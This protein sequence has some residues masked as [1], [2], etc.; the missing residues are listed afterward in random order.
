M[1]VN[2]DQLPPKTQRSSVN[3]IKKL[4]L[5]LLMG[6]I[7]VFI[8]ALLILNFW[9]APR[10]NQYRP[11]LE[12]LF[13]ERMGTSLQIGRLQARHH[14]LFP[15]FY[16]YDATLRDEHGQIALTVGQVE[17]HLSLWA[18]F[19]FDVQF[20]KLILEEPTLSIKRRED[21]HILI[22][23]IDITDIMQNQRKTE[24][25]QGLPDSLLWLL[26]QHQ[27]QIHNGKLS[28]S[29]NTNNAPDILVSELNLDIRKQQRKHFLQ[30]KATPPHA[31]GLPF[32]IEARFTEPT[33]SD[34]S[35]YLDWSGQIQASF[36]QANIE[37]LRHYVLL[38]FEIEKGKGSV[39]IRM[40][41]EHGEITQ[42][43]A[44]LQLAEVELQTARADQ[45]IRLLNLKG[46]F[47]G[48]WIQQVYRIHT[49]DL[50]FHLPEQTL[51]PDITLKEQDWQTGL[52]DISWAFD[53]QFRLNGG[54][55]QTGEIDL[56]LLANLA[57]RL[58]LPE[59]IQN[60]LV[61]SR[62]SGKI[63][64]IDLQW[65]GNF[66]QINT[67]SIKG[68]ISNLTLQAAPVA[69]P[70][71]GQKM[72]ITRPGLEKLNLSF[73]VTEQQGTIKLQMDEGEVTI[74]GLFSIPTLPISHLSAQGQW[75]WN[76]QGQVEFKIPSL[77][78]RNNSALINAQ[79][80]WL[81]PNP[82]QPED[83][84]GYLEL[85]GTLQKVQLNDIAR[86]L[87]NSIMP[88][89]RNYL[90]G[91]IITGI[92][93]QAQVT[94]KG[95]LADF[96]YHKKNTGF[97]LIEGKGRNV[98]FNYVPDAVRPPQQRAWPAFEQ[99]SADI[100]VTG[101]GLRA[102]HINGQ[103]QGI[104]DIRFYAPVLYID[105]W[106][107]HDTHVIANAEL[108]GPL[109][110]YLQ[111]IN[112]S[113]LGN[114]MH[115]TLSQASGTGSIKADLQLD[116]H[117]EQMKDS[118]V[119]GNVVFNKNTISLWPFTPEI[120]GVQGTLAFSEK[121]FSLPQFQAQTLGGPLTGHI[122]WHMNKG[123]DIAL[124][125]KLT[126]KGV[127]ND[128][129]WRKWLPARMEWVKGQ[130][131]YTINA[132]TKNQKTLLRIQSDL[133]GL[134]I[135]LPTPMQKTAA[136]RFPVTI[137]LTPVNQGN[138]F[139]PM[140]AEIKAPNNA[141]N[142][143]GIHGV[144]TFVKDQKSISISKGAI[145]IGATKLFTTPQNGITV[146][147]SVQTLNVPEWQ[148]FIKKL[149]GKTSL[150]PDISDASNLSLPHWWPQNT[151]AYIENLKATDSLELSQV[152]I[153]LKKQ[154]QTWQAHVDAP[155]VEGLIDWQFSHSHT[156][157]LLRGQLSRLWLPEPTV[158][159]IEPSLSVPP[160]SS[161]PFVLLPNTDLM[162]HDMRFGKI[163][164]EDVRLKA[165]MEKNPMR[166]VVNSLDFS[167]G[168]S[169]VTASGFWVDANPAFTQFD[170]ELQSKNTGELL[171]KLNRP[172]V[173]ANAQGALKGSLNWKAAP[174]QFDRSTLRGKLNLHL[175]KGQ[176][177]FTGPGAARILSFLSLQS[178]PNRLTLDFRDVFKK[179]LAFDKANANLTLQ[180]GILLV[181]SFQLSG[182]SA[183]VYLNGQ[184]NLLNKTQH[185]KA[186]VIPEVNAGTAS[187]AISAFNPAIGLG[188]LA[189]QLALRD[190]MRKALTRT[191]YVTG[192]W[193][194]AD[195][196]PQKPPSLSNDSGKTIYKTKKRKK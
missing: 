25:K 58:P 161:E 194:N 91:A 110:R 137:T 117:V 147:A 166:W 39:N 150:A 139:L 71:A 142:L 174:Y 105:D 183:Q 149:A 57:S 138:R 12:K 60:I 34:A 179:G 16:I 159:V 17:A 115:D 13:S 94:I 184:I 48:S 104:P 103:V 20:S 73:D 50:T 40:H 127:A 107:K 148:A 134:A 52:L 27:L 140:N 37:Q 180:D 191:Y 7:A 51:A 108:T 14:G 172:K 113:G 85:Q 9:I 193:D 102:S 72:Q 86:Y 164:I 171:E 132:Q 114:I 30:L 80:N 8:G 123:F 125:G 192:T 146:Q 56:A 190:P 130:T 61:Q 63:D 89:V 36:P 84:A 64:Y 21:N 168:S 66:N 186:I 187:L 196:S 83:T 96:P 163:E 88:K 15:E 173:I 185:L 141:N 131:P 49:N 1:P 136:S 154:G 42:T 112:H 43:T 97:L 44:G 47:T 189:A 124:Q 182:V 101:K 121:G 68:G 6:L 53:D 32:F 79:I 81:S 106:S 158:K 4:A 92:A 69:P 151:D 99:V 175:N 177:L 157:G 95:P 153:N 144:F 152:H 55:L 90:Q 169:P 118:Q 23:G 28:W 41:Y 111:F 22:A 167:I 188:S 70:V 26:R 156:Q 129:N 3:L 33:T 29:D 24:Q 155:Q 46:N 165:V 126:D 78:L 178:L 77:T 170:F 181:D 10:I 119:Q 67:Y 109:S 62:P 65:Q 19:A 122:Q 31:W 45:P 160:A 176:I 54:K 2:Q 162:I 74:P 116:L 195:I 120:T 87:P 133:Q 38:P 135:N 76:S 93:D 11:Q 18:L 128:T 35:N 75:T 59:S 98:V 143:P 145:A 100:Q 5:I 82:Q